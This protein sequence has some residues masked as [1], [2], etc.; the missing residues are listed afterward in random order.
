MIRDIGLNNLNISNS[1]ELAEAFSKVPS[2]VE[3]DNIWMILQTADKKYL[4]TRC[5]ASTFI[6]TIELDDDEVKYKSL[7]PPKDLSEAIHILQVLSSFGFG[8][9]NYVCG[10]VERKLEVDSN[11]NNEEP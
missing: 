3:Y 7:F 9:G 8:E 5:T 10:I 6:S 1:K 11:D 2:D 4:P